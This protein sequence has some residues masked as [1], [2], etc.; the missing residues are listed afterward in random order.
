MD[1]RLALISEHASPMAAIGGVD[2]G[3]QNIAVAELAKEL[4]NLGFSVDVFTR[5]CSPTEAEIV[6]WQPRIRVIHVPAGA[7]QYLPKEALLPHMGE[8]AQNMSRFIQT[9]AL[10]YAVTHAHFF[11]SGLV[12][13]KI[14]QLHRI[15]FVVTFHALGLVRRQC[16]GSSDGFPMERT[17]I[18]KRIMQEADGIVALCPQD[19]DD[20]IKLYGA[21]AS[22]ITI[23]P[24]GYNPQDFFPIRQELARQTLGLNVQEPTLLQLGRMVPRKGVDN[25][26]RAVAILRQTHGIAARLLVVGG[27][28]RQPDP[29]L[30]PEI[31][32]LQELAS[33]LGITDLVTFT[34]S[35]TRDELRHYYSAADVFVTTPWYEP[36]GITPLEAMACGTPVIGAAVGGIKHTVLLNKTGFLVQP[37]DPPALAEKLAVLIT[38]KALRQRYGQQAIQHVKTGYTWTRVAQQTAD[39]YDLITNGRVQTGFWLRAAGHQ[40]T[41]LP[42]P[43]RS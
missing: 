25:V 2:A 11:M 29:E 14:K 28:S 7:R 13:L 10:N 3:G 6:Q 15:P 26:I 39:L 30:T 37:N 8:F 34:G 20:L 23:I 12:A 17:L 43:D 31:G 1:K 32:R 41:S 27:D 5:C 33:A 42:I 21:D 16:Q 4:A 24:N 35:R 36:F 38:N 9:N 19:S 18:E 40:A 22:K